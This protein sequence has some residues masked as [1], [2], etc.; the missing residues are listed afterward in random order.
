MAVRN[1]STGFGWVSKSLHWVTVALVACQ[2]VVGVGEIEVFG[3]FDDVHGTIGTI[4]LAVTVL[5]LV[6]RKVVPLPPWDPRLS[7]AHR[8]LAHGIEVVLYAMLLVKPISG[9]LLLGAD[10]DDFDL[11]GRWEVPA[12]W[13]ES[14]FF[15]DV[16]EAVHF[17]S[18]VV[19]VAAILAHVALV[20]SKRLLPR[21]VPLARG[22]RQ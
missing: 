11:F 8:R 19:L 2:F 1:T 7:R 4:L 12:L 20:V 14:S 10:G 13:P 22:S 15:E 16:F 6:W 18:G 21:M 3:D 9:L 17:W 5:R